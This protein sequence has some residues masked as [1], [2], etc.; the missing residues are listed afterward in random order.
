MYKYPCPYKYVRHLDSRPVQKTLNN[1]LI[2]SDVE[3]SWGLTRM[4][5]RRM[6]LV[7]MTRILSLKETNFVTHSQSDQCHDKGKTTELYGETSWLSDC[8]SYNGKRINVDLHH[9][10]LPRL[11]IMEELKA[12]TKAELKVSIGC[13]WK[14]W[15]SSFRKDSLPQYDDLAHSKRELPAYA[16]VVVW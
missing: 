16:D 10:M 1:N 2:N 6:N 5:L 15:H 12:E 9:H 3:Q 4:R 11:L 7:I 14:R 8:G 13:D